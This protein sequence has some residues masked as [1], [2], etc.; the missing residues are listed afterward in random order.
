MR[1]KKLLWALQSNRMKETQTLCANAVKIEHVEEEKPN[2]FML[3]CDE[4]V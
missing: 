4:C 2:A 1:K 3:R